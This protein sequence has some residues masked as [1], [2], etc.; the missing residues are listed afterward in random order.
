MTEAAIKQSNIPIP[1]RSFSPSN[2]SMAFLKTLSVGHST[3][4]VEISL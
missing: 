4:I 3:V 1:K 2:K